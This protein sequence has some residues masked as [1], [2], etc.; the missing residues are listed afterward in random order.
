MTNEQWNDEV[1][2]SLKDSGWSVFSA[3]CA[4]NSD[5][6]FAHVNHTS[7]R[8]LQVKLALHKFLTPEQRK[9]EILRQL[10]S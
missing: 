3:G 5:T 10:S 9:A 1:I 2:A 7:G 4:Q 6:C 8:E